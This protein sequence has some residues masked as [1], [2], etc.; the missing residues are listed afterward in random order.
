[1]N[2]FFKRLLSFSIY[3]KLLPFLILYLVLINLR[4]KSNDLIGDESRY[5]QFS[6]NL[7]DGFYSPPFPDI[8]LWNGP[9]YPIFITPFIALDFSILAVRLT[10][11]LLL[12]FSL[13]FIYKT[14]KVYTTK[15]TALISAFVIGLY[16]PAYQMLYYILTEALSWFLVSLICF[17]LAILHKR[18]II[19]FKY[20][21]LSSFSIAYLALVKVIF[22]YVIAIVTLTATLLYLIPKLRA[23]LNK[24]ILTFYLSL[25]FC[26]PYLIYTYN[27]TGK[28][29][30]WTNSGGM[31]LYT[32]ST[33]YPDEFGD[34]SNTT[35]L[36]SNPRHRDF[37]Q[38]LST[39]TP[40]ERDE[41]FKR[42]AIENI[43]LNPKK[44]AANCFANIGRMLLDFPY[45][46][47][48]H[49]VNSLFYFFPSM[50]MIVFISVSI[51]FGIL[52]YKLVPFELYILLFFFL[53]YL[54]GSTFVSAYSRMFNITLPFWTLFIFYIFSNLFSIGK[55]QIKQGNH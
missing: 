42:K 14:I 16:F 2:R 37:I 28:F 24:S 12:Y 3:V 43:I 55:K 32:M 40:I 46:K 50:F 41:A 48:K 34:W 35:V 52:Y 36:E 7:I 5:I 49:H 29:F 45:T 53:T 19:S 4:S 18:K 13:I 10:N 30:Y 21:L 8:N 47:S 11:G 54:L 33:P 51:F 15:R 6:N 22:G 38:S 31:S 26:F 23:H 44:Y 9:G 1:M 27:L 17:S 39:L 25:L 20:L